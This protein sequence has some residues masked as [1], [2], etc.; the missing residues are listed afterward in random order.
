MKNFKTS[1]L[2]VIIAIIAIATGCKKDTQLN[3]STPNGSVVNTPN[4][5]TMYWPP[6]PPATGTWVPEGVAFY[7]LN[8][9]DN[10]DKKVII[11]KFLNTGID[12][13]GIIK[14]PLPIDSIAENWPANVKSGGFGYSSDMVI[15]AYMG[16]RQNGVNAS[17][18][19]NYRYDS[20]VHF[21]NG[22]GANFSDGMSWLNGKTPQGNATIKIPDG[23]GSY[24]ANNTIFYFKEGQCKLYYSQNLPM[25]ISSLVAGAGNYDWPNV[26]NVVSWTNTWGFYTH[27]FFDF[28]NWRYF[29]WEES[30]A[31]GGCLT[32]KLTMS[33]YKS[34]DKLLKWPA[35]W[36]K[37]N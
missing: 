18:K 28:K 20:L 22:W 29:S 33:G 13:M 11:A 14:G 5:L 16:M 37:A 27:V 3:A 1:I 35:G 6:L 32:I 25:S 31:S 34:L 12:T 24:S 36:G 9:D 19:I 21:T 4:F 2:I 8:H 10:K 26:S 30:C 23:V 7:D 15:S 17:G